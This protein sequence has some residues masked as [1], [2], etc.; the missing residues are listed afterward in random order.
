MFWHQDE[1]LYLTI[2]K[3][4]TSEYLKILDNGG[5]MILVIYTL[6]SPNNFWLFGFVKWYQLG[7]NKYYDLYNIHPLIYLISH[8]LKLRKKLDHSGIKFTSEA[9]VINI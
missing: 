9:K 6:I 4:C 3:K 7:T 2:T 5:P 8:S 1:K